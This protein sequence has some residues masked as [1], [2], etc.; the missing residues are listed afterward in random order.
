MQFAIG[1]AGCSTTTTTT[2]NIQ[3]DIVCHPHLPNTKYS[4]WQCTN[5]NVVHISDMCVC[6]CERCVRVCVSN[7]SLDS[8]K[9]MDVVLC[10][11]FMTAAAIT[12]T[13]T[14]AHN[15]LRPPNCSSTIFAVYCLLMLPQCSS[16]RNGRHRS[17]LMPII[18][19]LGS[20]HIRS[21]SVI[22]LPELPLSINT[23]TMV[24]AS[25]CNRIGRREYWKLVMRETTN[26]AGVEIVH[27]LCVKLVN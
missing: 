19:A 8:C 13:Q 22:R 10:A 16:F 9:F 27:C 5:N 18:I 6:I 24:G 21:L 17:Q 12:N 25:R 3:L 20:I 7:K 26:A 14:H 2:L 4:N 1:A 15:Y 23:R 11:Y